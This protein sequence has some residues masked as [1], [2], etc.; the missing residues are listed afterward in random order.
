M[1]VACED[2]AAAR[3]KVEHVESELSAVIEVHSKLLAIVENISKEMSRC[4]AQSAR[5][6]RGLQ[7]HA[8]EFEEKLTRQELRLAEV[9]RLHDAE[10]RMTKQF[11]ERVTSITDE[12]KCSLGDVNKQI[13]DALAKSQTEATQIRDELLRLRAETI[14]TFKREKVA[15]LSLDEQL[16]ESDKRLGQRIDILSQ[17]H[18]REHSLIGAH[19]HGSAGHVLDTSTKIESDMAC[20]MS[21]ISMDTN[22]ST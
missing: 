14:A 22:G 8:A 6:E 7:K 1:A 19:R 18:W 5:T 21:A 11:T 12:L 10:V 4:S 2:A 13:E 15:L 20:S 9:S 17:N 16:W 3:A